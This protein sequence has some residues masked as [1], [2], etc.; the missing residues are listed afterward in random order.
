MGGQTTVLLGAGASVDAGLPHSHRLTERLVESISGA[1]STGIRD[2]LYQV[3]GAIIAHDAKMGGN[4]YSG[5][6]AERVF[7]A[8]KMLAERDDLEIAPFISNW[9]DSRSGGRLPFGWASDFEKALN[10]KKPYS[11]ERLFRDGVGK[12][13]AASVS[14][15]VYGGLMGQM[16]GR[17]QTILTAKDIGH[18]AYLYPLF[19]LPAPVSIA[20][21]NYDLGVESAAQLYNIG[22]DRGAWGGGFDWSWRADSMYRLLKLHGSLDWDKGK[23]REALSGADSLDEDAAVVEAELKKS[24]GMTTP[25][26]VF[27]AREKL[28]AEGPF[29][30]ML[31][32]FSR[33][34]QATNHLIVVGYSFR[35]EHINV[36]IRDWLEGH[37]S[38]EL[39]I[40]DPSFPSMPG[41]YGYPPFVEWLSRK[42]YVEHV[43]GEDKY[44]NRPV[45]FEFRPGFDVFRKGARAA[46]PNACHPRLEFN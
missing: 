9:N 43:L 11:V 39:T 7:T 27:G 16:L 34:L 14:S 45:R 19:E 4:P 23:A 41:G 5:I 28:Q 17:L 1:G 13:T 32:E 25:E 29:L 2:A 38:P 8:V 37:A 26:I 36:L 44:G 6:D 22:L 30:A 35:D 18:F 20:T 12:L 15:A 40:V 31:L 10:A 42:V 33:W 21:L 24:F 3:V 46:L